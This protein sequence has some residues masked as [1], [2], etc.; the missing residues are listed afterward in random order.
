MREAM[1]CK[2]YK[3]ADEAIENL[4]QDGMTIMSGGFRS[5]AEFQ[6]I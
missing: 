6:K 3:N 4:L 2:I 5:D 1:N